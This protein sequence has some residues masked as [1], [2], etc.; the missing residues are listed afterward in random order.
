[1]SIKALRANIIVSIAVA[2]TGIMTPI[3]LSFVLKELV[4]ASSLQA[5][6]AGAALSATSLGTTFTILSTTDL[7][8]TR[9][10]TVTTC[11]AML[12]DVVGLVMVQVIANLGGSNTTFDPITVIRPVFVSVGFGV[13][14]F[15]LCSFCLKPILKILITKETKF[16]AF[17]QTAQSVFLVHTTILVGMVAG[18]TYAGTS[19]LFAAYLSGVIV[20]WFDECSAELKV[21]QIGVKSGVSGSGMGHSHAVL[22]EEGAQTEGRR[23]EHTSL[24]ASS[25][26]NESRDVPTGEIIYARYYR[27][28]VTRILIP[29]FFVSLFIYTSHSAKKKANNFRH[30]SVLRFR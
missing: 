13:G 4:S 19:S 23:A 10:G 5:F 29:F 24:S 8:S 9:L 18:A 6:A 17:M 26:M 11:A 2:I 7:I 16:P 25:A 30:P 12:D 3:A 15:I 28:P 20:K 1:M 14:V 27:D 22:Q 21:H